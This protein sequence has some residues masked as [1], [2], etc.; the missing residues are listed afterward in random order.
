MK[1]SNGLKVDEF[2]FT[3]V[4]LRRIGHKNDPFILASQAKQVFYVEDQVDRR[5][6]I[7]LEPSLKV[8]MDDVNEDDLCLGN[9][10]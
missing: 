7:V 8:P 5:W 4:D 9:T 1:S 10:E 6:P 2:G 3:L